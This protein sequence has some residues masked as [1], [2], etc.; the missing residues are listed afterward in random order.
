MDIRWARTLLEACRAAGVPA[1]M[2]QLG[3]FVRMGRSD[4]VQPCALGGGWRADGPGSDQ[5]IVEMPHS[6]GGDPI[7]WPEDLRVREWPRAA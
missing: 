5:G 6:K 4:A 1:F 2:K 7:Q 3:R